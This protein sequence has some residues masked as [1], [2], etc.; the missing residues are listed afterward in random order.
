MQTILV[1]I[2]IASFPILIFLAGYVLNRAR[3]HP[4][5]LVTA[6]TLFS[7][8]LIQLDQFLGQEFPG[9]TAWL[10]RIFWAAY[11]LPVALWV[12][13]AILLKPD[14]ELDL[15]L[16]R[17][18]WTLLLP[19]TV[20]FILGGWF[21]N[22]LVD[23]QTRQPATLYSLF[24]IYNVAVTLGAL[25]LLHQNY[26]LTSPND[27]LRRAFAWL[28]IGGLGYRGGMVVLLTGLIDPNWVFALLIVDI[29]I[30]GIASLWY[31]AIAEG[32]T[33]R[34]DLRFT[35]VKTLLILTVILSPWIMVLLS[36]D[37]WSVSY[38]LGLFF[39][40]GM[41][42]LGITLQED[43]E[44]LLDWQLGEEE[45]STRQALRTLIA[46][47]TRQPD[48]LTS[49]LERDHDEFVR[50]TRRALSH[51]PNLPRLAASPLTQLRIIQQRV[52][53]KANALQRANELRLLLLEC[54]DALR[55]PDRGDFGTTDEWRFFNALY[56]PYVIGISPYK[57][58]LFYETF[59]EPT[60]AVIRWFQTSVPP[61]TLYNWQNRGAEM[62]ADIL[63]ERERLI[64]ESR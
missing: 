32:Q 44:H 19:V 51:M 7:Y 34:R 13:I 63:L 2:Q 14:D 53:S 41:V 9:D 37:V 29:I 11:P 49:P 8:A 30:L 20:L 28:R 48:S 40:L 62:I 16:D 58:S 42:P 57:R 64:A 35:A 26:H 5:A 50:L 1:A 17:I 55:P 45:Q 60:A 38:A 15:W 54:I 3:F 56:Y 46:N 21:G 10:G 27:P 61:R 39:A 31:D 23:F 22:D 47:T 52:D 12:R 25:F 43:I 18:W 6:L 24:T 33:I 4:V 36:E 59:D